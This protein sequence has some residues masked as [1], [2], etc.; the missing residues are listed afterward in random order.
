M[1]RGRPPGAGPGIASGVSEFYARR[2]EFKLHHHGLVDS[3]SE[4]AFARLAEGSARHGDV[5]VARGQT[6]GRGTQ[7]RSW[8]SAP[9]E[10]L[11]LS[12]VLLPDP[13]QYKPPALTIATGLAVV[14]ALTDLGL[15]PFGEKAP[16]LDWPND[17]VVDGQ[18]LCG[19]LTESRGLDEKRPHYVIGIGLNV[20]QLSFPA[21]L[22]RERAVTSLALLGLDLT[23]DAVLE[24]LLARLGPRLGQV[25]RHHERLATDYL[26]ATGLL[27]RVVSVSSSS[28]LHRGKL[29]G[30]GLSAGLEIELESGD[31]L[32]L[33]LEFVRSVR[34]L[35]STP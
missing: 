20:R 23:R 24:A 15:P 7:G 10:G 6:A 11:Y 5:H 21:E 2:M 34:A 16:A 30:L 3:T 19:I 4:R 26:R 1:P 29:V 32:R 12:V 27:G 22:T 9:D 33:P 13:P 14:E 8:H 28:E 35:S 17:V 25:R 31:L 18:K